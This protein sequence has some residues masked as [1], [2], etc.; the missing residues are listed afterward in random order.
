MFLRLGNGVTLV[1]NECLRLKA[2]F[3]HL[4][5]ILNVILKNHFEKQDAN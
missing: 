5:I 4:L 3:L 2:T 1:E